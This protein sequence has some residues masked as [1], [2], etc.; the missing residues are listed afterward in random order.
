MSDELDI[1]YDDEWDDFAD[2]LNIMYWRLGSDVAVVSSVEVFKDDMI[3]I[4]WRVGHVLDLRMLELD[5]SE[6][7]YEYIV[8]R[9]ARDIRW[10]VGAVKA[11]LRY[12][13]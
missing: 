10:N 6:N 11:F 3:F 12:E 4:H 13:F 9:I 5:I 2:R 7:E 8:R 1:F